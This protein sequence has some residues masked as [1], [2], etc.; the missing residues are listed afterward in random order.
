MPFTSIKDYWI[1]EKKGFTIP[2]DLLMALKLRGITGTRI[3]NAASY[4]SLLK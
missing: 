4:Y 2:K 1:M 3:K